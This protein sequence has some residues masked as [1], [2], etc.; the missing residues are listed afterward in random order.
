MATVAAVA[1]VYLLAHVR[2]A[3]RGPG[4]GDDESSAAEALPLLVL[5]HNRAQALKSVISQL[6]KMRSF[7]VTTMNKTNAAKLYPI[8]VSIDGGH[9]PTLEVARRMAEH[10]IRAHYDRRPTQGVKE[11]LRGYYHIASH[12]RYAFDAVFALNERFQ[13]VIV[14]EDDFLLSPDFL[15]YFRFFRPLLSI[16]SS[17]MTVSAWNDNGFVDN[18]AQYA[19]YMVHRSDFFPGLGWIMTRA[20]WKELRPKWPQAYW[21]DWLRASDQRKNRSCIRPELSRVSMS[22]WASKGVSK[23]Q[24]YANHIG[25]VECLP[26][27]RLR[28]EELDSDKTF[29][30]L[31]KERYDELLCSKIKQCEGTAVGERKPP[32]V[33]LWP[34]SE[35]CE[36]EKYRDSVEMAHL[37]ES[38][39]LMSDVRGG[40]FR[41]I[42]NGVVQRVRN[43]KRIFLVPQGRLDYCQ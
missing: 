13:D 21:D 22:R 20:L 11:H 7:E 19:P 24:F 36:V 38:Y 39:G 9:T 37:L 42:Y 28:W 26:E 15:A 40:L 16:D 1:I 29:G 35:E 25:K 14:L 17:I 5:A 31:V 3:G 23:G 32:T 12:Y 4:P 8:I 18:V 27:R 33:V 10:V 2:M 43:G 30:Y 41:T 6:H 34:E